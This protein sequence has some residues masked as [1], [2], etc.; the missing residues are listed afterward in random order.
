MVQHFPPPANPFGLKF[1]EG[2]HRIYKAHGQGV[3]GSVLTAEKPDLPGLALAHQPRQIAGPKTAI[4]AAHPGAGLAKNRILGRQA[5]VAEQ[6]QHLASPNRI[7]RHQGN[8]HLGEAANQA[9]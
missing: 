4:E 6:V 7:A 8:H 3:L 9:L 2:H 5:E 1:L